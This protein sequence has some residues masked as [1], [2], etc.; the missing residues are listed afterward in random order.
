ML[1]PAARM[2]V[3]KIVFL[4]D[5]DNTL[6]DNDCFAADLRA[7]LSAAFGGAVGAEGRRRSTDG[8]PSVV[9]SAGCSSRA[10]RKLTAPVHRRG[11][12]KPWPG[13][14]L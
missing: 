8:K 13:S 5:V 7:R 10:L 1:N 6:L 9:T 3:D 11:D 2:P 14:G 12:S 4:L